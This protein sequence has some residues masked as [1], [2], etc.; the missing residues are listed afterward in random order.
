M[1]EAEVLG[2]VQM[3]PLWLPGW[4]TEESQAPFLK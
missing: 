3:L 1:T 4:E 2:L